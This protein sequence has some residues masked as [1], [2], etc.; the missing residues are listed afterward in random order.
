[1]CPLVLADDAC[2]LRELTSERAACLRV[3]V[4]GCLHFFEEQDEIEDAH[5]LLFRP[6]PRRDARQASQQH[7]PRGDRPARDDS[8]FEQALSRQAGLCARRAR[9]GYIVVK[10]E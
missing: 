7:A 1:M 8:T 3:P 10:P 5:V 9:R 6:C 4:E 2:E